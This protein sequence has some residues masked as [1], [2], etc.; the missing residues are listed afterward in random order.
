MIAMEINKRKLNEDQLQ[1]FKQATFQNTWWLYPGIFISAVLAAL[2]SDNL[3]LPARVTFIFVIAFLIFWVLFVQRRI[4][5]TDLPKSF[6]KTDMILSGILLTIL[7]GF[8]T[9]LTFFDK[10]K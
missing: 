5:K 2:L 10:T 3:A 6:V 4:S 8:I 1:S 7:C 9:W